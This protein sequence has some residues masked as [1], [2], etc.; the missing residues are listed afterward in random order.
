MP[1]AA[2]K[3][4]QLQLQYPN[5]RCIPALFVFFFFSL[6][7]LVRLFSVSFFSPPR[8]KKKRNSFCPGRTFL[9]YLHAQF[10]TS[11]RLA[12]NKVEE[13]EQEQN[14]EGGFENHDTIKDECGLICTD[15][16]M[17]TPALDTAPSAYDWLVKVLDLLLVLEQYDRAPHCPPKLCNCCSCLHR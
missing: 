9:F 17:L 4:T 8:K 11:H 6:S 14:E 3:H 2:S 12:A 13:E 1:L 5:K 7:L 10:S 16:L 15:T